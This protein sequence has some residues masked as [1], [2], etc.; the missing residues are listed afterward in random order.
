MRP[1]TRQER[2]ADLR[3]ML[4]TGLMKIEDDGGSMG[5]AAVEL[6]KA[7]LIL[8]LAANGPA[9]TLAGVTAQLEQ[10]GTAFPR[11]AAAAETGRAFPAVKG[12]A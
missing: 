6:I 8:S 12:S 1:M 5:D 7:G 11:E 3:R 9:A 2:F 10:L 4:V